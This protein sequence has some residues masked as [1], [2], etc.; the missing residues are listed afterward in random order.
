MAEK[1][2]V[3][4]KDGEAILGELDSIAEFIQEKKGGAAR[5]SSV[6]PDYWGDLDEVQTRL[7][8]L[9]S[10]VEKLLKAVRDAVLDELVSIDRMM[11]NVVHLGDKNEKRNMEPIRFKAQDLMRKVLALIGKVGQQEP[12]QAP[13]QEVVKG[14]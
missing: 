3:K 8:A 9:R 4:E 7:I 5:F 12:G 1:E 10:D 14:S 13:E 2:A 11:M 6:R